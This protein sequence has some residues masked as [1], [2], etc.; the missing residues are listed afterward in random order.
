MLSCAV[1]A[2]LI[3]TLLGNTTAALRRSSWIE[4]RPRRV[5]WSVPYALSF[6]QSSIGRDWVDTCAAHHRGVCDFSRIL[7]GER[8]F[9]D[10]NRGLPL[11]VTSDSF[12]E[13][14]LLR[15][16]PHTWGPAAAFLACFRRRIKRIRIHAKATR[17]AMTSATNKISM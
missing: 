8:R 6:T 12:M 10:S 13:K 11:V 5:R 9:Y 17:T 16:K 4:G 3:N 14:P 15:M 1:E 7:V 2:A